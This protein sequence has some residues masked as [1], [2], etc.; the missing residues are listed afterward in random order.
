M[1]IVDGVVVSESA[2]IENEHSKI[3]IKMASGRRFIECV[4]IWGKWEVQSAG[5]ERRYCTG[6]C[7]SFEVRPKTSK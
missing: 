2:W 4:H 5:V 6:D 7:K 3:Y 1:A